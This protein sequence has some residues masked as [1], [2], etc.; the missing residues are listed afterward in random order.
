MLLVLQLLVL[1]AF[2]GWAIG[3]LFDLRLQHDA[4]LQIGLGIL[5]AGVAGGTIIVFRQQALIGFLLYSF[6]LAAIGGT[7]LIRLV[8]RL[9]RGA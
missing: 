2:A 8:P 4:L 7:I 9:I 3:R 5:G 1:G 6:L